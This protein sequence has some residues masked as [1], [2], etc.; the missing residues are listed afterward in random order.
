MR[1]LAQPA[2]RSDKTV[3]R[4]YQATIARPVAFEQHA[5]LLDQETLEALRRLFPGGTA[6]M[7]GVMPGKGQ[8]NLPHIRKMIPGSWVFFSGDKRLYLGGTVALTWRNPELAARLWSRD[9]DT[10]D[11]W[12]YMY[13]LSGTRE[14]D[15]P[16]EEIRDLL[17]WNPN[18]NIM[19]FQ[20]FTETEADLLQRRYSLEALVSTSA[21]S[22]PGKPVDA[23]QSLP[24]LNSDAASAEDLLSNEGDV[25]MLAKLAVARSTA[26]PLAIALLGEWGAGKSSFISQMSRRVYE[27]TH[28]NPGNPNRPSAF[29]SKVCQVHFNAWHYSDEHVWSGL[30]DHLFQKLASTL[31]EESPP[32]QTAE[33]QQQKEA[34]LNRL[35]RDQEFLEEQLDRSSWER[36][37]GFLSNLGPIVEAPRLLFTSVRL[38]LRDIR[39]SLVPIS[40]WLLSVVAI[41][42]ALALKTPVS[43]WLA[44]S[45]GAIGVFAAPFLLVWRALRAA[46]VE[47]KKRGWSAP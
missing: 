26:P 7:W 46:H 3:A 33:E 2:R 4:H 34:R 43:S 10:G 45:I 14:F 32:A 18:R 6:Q 22:V 35:T 19:G 30:A 28:E 16:I 24:E 17:D 1:I 40:V 31:P 21:E 29:T 5:D 39:R 42:L 12:E 13:A 9:P 11:T 36:P 41:A 15:I 25:D 37:T 38:L 27:L 44:V 47:G 23:T 20:A 8:R